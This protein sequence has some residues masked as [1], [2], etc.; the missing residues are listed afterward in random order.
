MGCWDDRNGFL[1]QVEASLTASFIDVGE[2]F[3][4]VAQSHLGGIQQDMR[5][6]IAFHDRINRPSHD[7]ARGQITQ[8]VKIFHEGPTINIF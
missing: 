6:T 1:G 4:Q 7:V 3:R 2:S 8:R 5:R